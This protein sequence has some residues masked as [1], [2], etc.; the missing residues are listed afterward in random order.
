MKRWTLAALICGASLTQVS[1]AQDAR[2]FG[3]YGIYGFGI[4]SCGTWVNARASD[5]AKAT[6]MTTYVL[7]YVSG[8]GVVLSA[9]HVSTTETDVGGMQVF[10]DNYCRSHPNSKFSEAAGALVGD[11]IAKQSTTPSH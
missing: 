7:G 8:A 1:V 9:Y 6:W 5:E 4:S 10:L 2:P 3:E 11:L